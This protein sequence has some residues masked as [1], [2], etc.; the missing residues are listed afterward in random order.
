LVLTWQSKTK[1]QFKLRCHA[2]CTYPTSQTTQL[3]ASIDIH[4][5][6]M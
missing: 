3:V 1:E 5:N 6:P 4:S 2:D